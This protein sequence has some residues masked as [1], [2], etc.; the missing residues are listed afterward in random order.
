VPIGY[1]RHVGKRRRAQARNE[2]SVGSGTERDPL[3]RFDLFPFT[4]L[5]SS[6]LIVA[7]NIDI[8]SD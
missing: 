6:R 5:G 2:L 1:D 7:M 3:F 8:A 4:R